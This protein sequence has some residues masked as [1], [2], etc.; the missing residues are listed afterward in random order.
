MT[1]ELSF[2]DSTSVKKVCKNWNDQNHWQI[3][4]IKTTDTIVYNIEIVARPVLYVI[5]IM[6]VWFLTWSCWMSTLWRLSLL[7]TV[8]Q[9]WQM[10]ENS[11]MILLVATLMMVMS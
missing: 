11:S 3:S 10:W 6:N 4:N 1:K 5:D 2:S 7:L 8:Q 9:N